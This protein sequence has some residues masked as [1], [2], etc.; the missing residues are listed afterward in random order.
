MTELDKFH[1]ENIK[2]NGK[3]HTDTGPSGLVTCLVCLALVLATLGAFQI[4]VLIYLG[5]L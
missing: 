1:Q 5:Y 4:A 2:K 3:L